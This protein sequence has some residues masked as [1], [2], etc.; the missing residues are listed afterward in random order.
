[1]FDIQ[2]DGGPSSSSFKVKYTLNL[3]MNVSSLTMAYITID[4]KYTSINTYY[5][6]LFETLGGVNSNAFAQYSGTG[7]QWFRLQEYHRYTVH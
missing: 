2:M 1:M 3:A 6:I 5:D 4:S 7:E